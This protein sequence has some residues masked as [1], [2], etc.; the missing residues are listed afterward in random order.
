MNMTTICKLDT[1]N[2]PISK[3]ST[4]EIKF[5]LKERY[6]HKREKKKGKKIRRN[7]VSSYYCFLDHAGTH[8]EKKPELCWFVL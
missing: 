6:I 3:S 4:V 5:I 2:P 8:L 1:N 7:N